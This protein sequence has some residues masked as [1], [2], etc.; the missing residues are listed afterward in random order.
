MEIH[1]LYHVYADGLWQ[2]PLREH[3]D[4]LHT[5]GLYEQLDRFYVGIVGND[6]NVAAVKAALDG[7]ECS[8]VAESATGWEQES[9]RLLPALLGDTDAAVLYCH[10]KGAAYPSEIN[11]KWRYSMTFFTVVEWW[12]ALLALEDHDAYGCHVV[13]HDFWPED[14]FGGNFWWATADY[15]RSLPPVAE[16]DRWDA[17]RWIGR[18]EAPRFFDANPGWPDPSLFVVSWTYD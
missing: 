10:T 14:F 11:V 16:D 7:V 6:E 18:G 4:A 13:K 5:S 3:L 1:H 2:A 15:L 9:L 8:V 12:R 17:E